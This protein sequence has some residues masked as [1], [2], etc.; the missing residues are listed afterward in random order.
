MFEALSNS[1]KVPTEK[2]ITVALNRIIKD[3][4]MLNSGA[5]NMDKYL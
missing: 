1:R 4:I 3:K 5:V 2:D